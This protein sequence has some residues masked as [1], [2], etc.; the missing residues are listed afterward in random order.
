MPPKKD[1]KKGGPAAGQPVEE[2]LTDVALLP[3]LNEF[4]F[5][6]LYAFKYKQN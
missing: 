6:N 1:V 3:A 4:V 2:D 5:M